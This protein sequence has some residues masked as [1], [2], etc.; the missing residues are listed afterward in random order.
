MKILK[1]FVISLSIILIA[2]I[3]WVIVSVDWGNLY[4]TVGLYRNIETNKCVRFDSEH[5][6]KKELD[7]N[8]EHYIL[9]SNCK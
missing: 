2:V 6:S 1:Y 4:V 8:G 9:D 3:V 5:G 7:F